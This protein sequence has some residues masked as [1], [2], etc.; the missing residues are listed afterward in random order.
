MGISQP[1]VSSQIKKFEHEIGIPLFRQ[2]GRGV[3]LTDFGKTLVE[4]AQNFFLLK[5]ISKRLLKIIV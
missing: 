3:L 4:K 1:A 2:H 5:N